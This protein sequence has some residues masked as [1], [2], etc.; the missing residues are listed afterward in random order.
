MVAIQQ[1]VLISADLE[2]VAGVVGS[3][4][5]RPG[6]PEYETARRL[7]TGEV[8]AAVRGILDADADAGAG[9]DIVVADSHGTYRNLLVEQ[10]HPQARLL[11]G[12]PRTLAMVHDV[13][14]ADAVMFIGYH[15]RAG[16]PGLLCHTFHDVVRDVRCNGRSLGEAGLNAAVASHLGAPLWLATGDDALVDE[17]RDLAPR[18]VTV[19]VK[20]AVSTFAAESLHPSVACERIEAAARTAA[21]QG[22]GGVVTIPG[23][24]TV[25]VDLANPG[26]ADQAAVPPPLTR[27]GPVT[28][29]VDVDDIVQAYRWVRT[30]IALASAAP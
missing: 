15:G 23:P 26:Q 13:E 10:L 22:A 7:M 6:N 30:V 14:R 16:R 17:I 5:L 24:I 28:V 3:E 1:R 19:S 12:R 27:L 20:R 4:E 9:A 21:H 18:V 29:A 2:G 8:N 11:R 25:E